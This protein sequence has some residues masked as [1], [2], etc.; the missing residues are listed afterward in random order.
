MARVEGMPA[1][2]PRSRPAVGLV[3]RFGDWLCRLDGGIA[4]NAGFLVGHSAPPAGGDGR[5]A[6]GSQG[7]QRMI[8]GMV[9]SSTTP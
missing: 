6:V 5:R 7:R 9:A 4:I 8:G 1:G 3:G 2:R